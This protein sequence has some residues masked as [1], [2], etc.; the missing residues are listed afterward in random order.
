MKIQY[1][2]VALK[3]IGE[4]DSK[5]KLRIKKAIEGIPKGD[6]KSL[7]GKDNECRLRVGKY[8]VVFEYIEVNDKILCITEIGS[9][10]DIYK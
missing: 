6:I 9:R 1:T 8:R 10:G 3:A 7:R 5:T 2:K 4:M